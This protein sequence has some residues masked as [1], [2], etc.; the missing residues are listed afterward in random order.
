MDS[1]VPDEMGSRVEPGVELWSELWIS[2][3]SLLQSY[4][5]VHGLHA[6]RRAEMEWDQS[7]I[8]VCH[9]E[10]RLELRRENALVTWVRENGMGGRL[11]LTAA[12]RLRDAAEGAFEVKAGAADA[13]GEEMDMAAEKWARELMQ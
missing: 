2:L 4:T 9:R 1:V 6:N 11:K 10:K 3:A 8:T 12:G 7:R 5:S 13:G